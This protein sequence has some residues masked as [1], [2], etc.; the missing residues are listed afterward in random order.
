MEH[1]FD[2]PTPMATWRVAVNLWY[3]TASSLLA[4]LC[5]IW[6]RSLA[7]RWAGPSRTEVRMWKA[8][9]ENCRRLPSV[10]AAFVHR[11]ETLVPVASILRHRIGGNGLLQFEVE[12]DTDEDE[13]DVLVPPAPTWECITQLRGSSTTS[14]PPPV[15]GRGQ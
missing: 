6:S 9:R 15:G 3:I 14:T 1:L 8:L 10:R 4:R 11:R 7:G 13:E 5:Y 2:L 12:W